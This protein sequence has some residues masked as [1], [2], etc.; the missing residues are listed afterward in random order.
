MA[1]KRGYA[2]PLTV[3]IPT[4]LSL[5]GFVLAMIALFAGSGSQ[6]QSLEKYHIIAVNMSTFGHNL[7]PTSSSSGSQPTATNDDGFG[8][9]DI[10]DGLDD[11]EGQITDEL[12]DIANDV[13]D[14]LSRELG[15][16]QWYSVHVMTA[17]EGNFAPNATSPGA[18]YNTTNCTAQ[19]AGVN[20]NLTEIIQRELNNGPLKINAADIPIPDSIQQSLDYV[21]KFL[22]A[23]FVL[24]VLGAGFSGLCFLS[25]IVLLTLRRDVIG[26]GAILFNMLLALLA[27]LSLAVGAAIA[28]AISKRGASEINDQG[29][30]IGISAI[31]GTPFM[32]ISWVAFAVMFVALAFW[33][34]SC[35]T[36]RR[37]LGSPAAA[38]SAYNREKTP[39]ASSD[40]NRGLLGMFRRRY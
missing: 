37:Q 28:T 6:K 1:V 5:A 30:D 38:T 19:S 27:A 29:A 40:S 7:I 31:E 11:I 14:Q 39:R 22:L 35:C 3:V 36:P 4:L 10:Q 13:A 25:C 33:T 18:W 12:N 23:T 16:S 21:N 26:R 17:C 2:R 9:D 24:Y 15:I 32:I 34:V 8:W 20:L